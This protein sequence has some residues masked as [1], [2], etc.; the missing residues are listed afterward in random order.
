MQ[1]RIESCRVD[2]SACMALCNAV[3]SKNGDIGTVI[4]CNVEFDA[5]ATYIGYDVQVL[6]GGG[7]P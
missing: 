3:A 5:S 4:A 2:V 7:V 1:L 6:I